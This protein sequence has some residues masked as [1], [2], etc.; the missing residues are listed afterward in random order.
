LN[1]QKDKNSQEINELIQTIQS[2]EELMK[3]RQDYANKIHTQD[4]DRKS[5]ERQKSSGQLQAEQNINDQRIENLE[6]L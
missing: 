6:N 1:V 4:T 2:D 5:L 3:N